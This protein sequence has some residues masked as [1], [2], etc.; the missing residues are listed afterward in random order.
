MI[1]NFVFSLKYGYQEEN[2]QLVGKFTEGKNPTENQKLID[3]KK[4]GLLLLHCML[5]TEQCD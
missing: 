2:C 4:S 5:N 3:E 1:K